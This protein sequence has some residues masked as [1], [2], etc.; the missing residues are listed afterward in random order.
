MLSGVHTKEGQTASLT[1]YD[2][3]SKIG[4][5]FHSLAGQVAFFIQILIRN[6]A[7]KFGVRGGSYCTVVARFGRLL[8]GAK[9]DTVA[10]HTAKTI[11]CF[12]FPTTLWGC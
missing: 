9:C 8:G 5:S 7:P 3:G 1:F 2:V 12:V 11:G 6:F 10:W 4:M